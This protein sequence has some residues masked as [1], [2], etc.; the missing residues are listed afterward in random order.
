MNL[1]NLSDTE[2]YIDENCLKNLSWVEELENCD[3]KNND[4]DILKI[5]FIDLTDLKLLEYQNIII[6][7]LR[8][9]SN[10]ISLDKI[11][12]LIESSKYLSNKLNLP[13]FYHRHSDNNIPRS[14]YKFCELTHNCDFNYNIKKNGCYLQHFVHNLIHADLCALKNYIQNKQGTKINEIQKSI[15]TI[16]YVINHMYDELQNSKRHIQR[17][18]KKNNKLTSI[19]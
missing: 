14:S 11:D 8:K 2:L 13:L 16:S 1:I 7:N 15:N 17:Y 10:N 19:A 18:S 9:E 6:G 12:W 5:R 3:E 4:V